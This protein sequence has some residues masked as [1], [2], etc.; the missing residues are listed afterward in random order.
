[1]EAADWRTRQQPEI[2]RFVEQTGIAVL[3]GFV[4]LT[5]RYADGEMTHPAMAEILD[6]SRAVA[7][8]ILEETF[9]ILD[10]VPEAEHARPGDRSDEDIETR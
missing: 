6:V 9:P 5:R 10:I 3:S 1:M 4:E 2:H 8:D 7:F